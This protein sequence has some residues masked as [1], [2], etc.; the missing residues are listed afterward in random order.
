MTKGFARAHPTVMGG[1][2]PGKRL[3]SE[4]VKLSTQTSQLKPPETLLN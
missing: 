4:A 2:F 1:F 3:K